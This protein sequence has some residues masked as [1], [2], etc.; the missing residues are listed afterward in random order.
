[1]FWFPT[2]T[3]GR[4]GGPGGAAIKKSA[5]GAVAFILAD[6]ATAGGTSG[7]KPSNQG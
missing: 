4:S 7:N 5:R 2:Q 6:H 3:K 1:V